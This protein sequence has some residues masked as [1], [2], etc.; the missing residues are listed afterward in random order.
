MILHGGAM[1]N[2][3]NLANASPRRVWVVGLGIA[4]QSWYLWFSAIDPRHNPGLLILLVLSLLPI[5]S[6]LVRRWSSQGPGLVK[7]YLSPR[8]CLQLDDQ[9]DPLLLQVMMPLAMM[10][11][12]MA[13]AVWVLFACNGG[14]LVVLMCIACLWIIGAGSVLWK[15]I[16]RIGMPK[17]R[18]RPA[19]ILAAAGHRWSGE[20]EWFLKPT[21]T[22]YAHLDIWQKVRW[23]EFQGEFVDAE[24]ACDAERCVRVMKLIEQWIAQAAISSGEQKEE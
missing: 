17:R 3:A 24:V 11:L 12:G 4:F 20:E 5:F 8:G 18:I 13:G 2:K 16:K 7:V 1:G 22:G 10:I 9:A 23:H 6:L 21:R 14:T 15:R 19:E